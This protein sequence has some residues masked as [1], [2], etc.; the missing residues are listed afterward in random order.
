MDVFKTIMTFIDLFLI[1]PIFI[2][3]YWENTMLGIIKINNKV[4]LVHN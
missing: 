1:Q 3:C 2:E 4:I